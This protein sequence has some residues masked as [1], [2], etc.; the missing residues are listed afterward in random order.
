[1]IA[2]HH[3]AIPAVRTEVKAE[4]VRSLSPGCSARSF[5]LDRKEQRVAPADPIW[6]TRP[7]VGPIA[8]WSVNDVSN[9]VRVAFRDGRVREFRLKR[10]EFENGDFF[11]ESMLPLGPKTLFV[12]H[13]Q[14]GYTVDSEG[15][16]LH[17]LLPDRYID[18]VV[19]RAKVVRRVYEAG[20]ADASGNGPAKALW[21][22]VTIALK[23]SG[24]RAPLLIVPKN[25]T[26]LHSYS[27]EGATI[28][29]VTPVGSNGWT[30]VTRRHGARQA[31][32]ISNAGKVTVGVPHAWR[33]QRTTASFSFLQTRRL[34]DF[35]APD[36]RRGA[37]LGRTET[38][39]TI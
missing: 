13:N 35:R 8:T 3:Y 10:Y 39:P 29:A 16:V 37:H 22:G 34:E 25:L 9:R 21:N 33:P 7:G 31:V 20:F 38:L 23:Y 26:W 18:V 19:T 30:V 2:V 11:L 15:H 36:R 6:T 32:R 28:E 27:F 4:L 24:A 14:G 1:M 12:L 17:E 5:D